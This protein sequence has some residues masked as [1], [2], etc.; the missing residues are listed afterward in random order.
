MPSPFSHSTRQI[1]PITESAFTPFGKILKHPGGRD[2]LYLD[3]AF[4]NS[5]GS[6]KAVWINDPPRAR[7]PVAIR[8]LEKHPFTPQ[9]FIPMHECEYLAIAC[10]SSEQGDAILSSLRAF[11]VTG[12]SSIIY[13][14]N[15]WHHGLLPFREDTNFVVMQSV[16]DSGGDIV[17]TL[18][19]KIELTND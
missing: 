9:A 8:S 3:C 1:E 10:L 12:S 19:S 11:R 13:S 17:H 5:P 6:S 15:V 18:D 2:R 4:G 14:A 7:F 16:A